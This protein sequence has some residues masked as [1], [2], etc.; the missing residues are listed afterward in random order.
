[1]SGRAKAQAVS[2]RPPSAQVRVRSRVSPCGICDGQS[3]TGTG[4]SPSTSVFPCQFHSTGA[5][6]LGKMKK[7]RQ[8]SRPSND[9]TIDRDR[10]IVLFLRT[11]SISKFI[12]RRGWMSEWIWICMQG[13]PLERRPLGRPRHRCEGDIKTG[14]KEIQW[15][16]VVLIRLIQ[17]KEQV[18][19]V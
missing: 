19:V 5:P 16:S 6:L 8:I 7:K 10:R 1:M 11:L 15:K 14:L 17:G 4:F 13:Q 9:A 12:Q 2:R 3:G 18:G